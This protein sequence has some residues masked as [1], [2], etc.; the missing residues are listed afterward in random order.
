MGVV[1]IDVDIEVDV[2]VEVDKI[3]FPI[4]DG[5]G[6]LKVVPSEKIIP[7]K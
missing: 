7:Q 2:D 4:R 1:D 6:T 5:G 3:C